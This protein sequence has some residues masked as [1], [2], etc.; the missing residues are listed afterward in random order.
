MIDDADGP[1]AGRGGGEAGGG[2]EPAGADHEGFGGQELPLTAPPHLGKDDVAGVAV[3]LL[4]SEGR[5][6]ERT[7]SRSMGSTFTPFSLSHA[8]PLRRS[9]SVPSSSSAT[10]P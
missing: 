7:T 6:H 4:F 2:A 8:I 9:S 10:Q 3:D 5:L 1:H